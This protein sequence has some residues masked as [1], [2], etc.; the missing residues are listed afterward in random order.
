M[1]RLAAQP[2]LFAAPE[3]EPAPTPAPDPLAALAEMRDRLAAAPA[4]PWP[5]LSAAMAEEYRALA[6][7]REAGPEGAAL[8]AAILQQTER[9]LAM[10]D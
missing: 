10:T 6:L 8:A 4:P 9:L 5:N 1:S 7:A 2:D 3:P